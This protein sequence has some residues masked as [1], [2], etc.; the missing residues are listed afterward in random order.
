MKKALLEALQKKYEANIAEADA[1][2]KIYFE[3]SVGIGEHP[4]HIK[5][6]DKLISTIADNEGKIEILKEFK[7]G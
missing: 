7:D 4:T 1:T 2:A 5:E 3:N 6:L